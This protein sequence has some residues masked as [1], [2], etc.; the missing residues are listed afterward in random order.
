VAKGR[1]DD[2]RAFLKWAQDTGFTLVRVLAMNPHGWFDLSVD[3]GRRALPQLLSIAGEYSLRVQIVALANTA[4]TGRG[5]SARAG[6]RGGAP[7]FAV[8]QLRDGDRQRAVSPDAG[9]AE[10]SGADAPTST[11]RARQRRRRMGCRSGRTHPHRS[12]AA[13]S[14]S[15]TWRAAAS[16][17]T[18]SRG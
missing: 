8:R 1:L 2:A 15:S 16:A 5:V 6:S 7:L 11:A 3:D 13:T 14:W 12:P 4:G 9:A 18:A 17:G 10:R